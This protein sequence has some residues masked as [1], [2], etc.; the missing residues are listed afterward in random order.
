MSEIGNSLTLNVGYTFS[1][2]SDNKLYFDWVYDN[3][4]KG[5]ARSTKNGIGEPVSNSF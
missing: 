3:Y 1:H 4:H 5:I 2:F